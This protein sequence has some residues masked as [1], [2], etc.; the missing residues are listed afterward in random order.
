MSM[1]D[2]YHEKDEINELINEN[3]HILSNHKVMRLFSN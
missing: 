2:F 3:Y 1:L